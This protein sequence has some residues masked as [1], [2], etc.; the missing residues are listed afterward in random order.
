MCLIYKED[1][2]HKEKINYNGIN[3]ETNILIESDPT[4][5]FISSI[6]NFILLDFK[7]RLTWSA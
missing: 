1:L 5:N 2:K 4:N 6:N 3:Q 7:M